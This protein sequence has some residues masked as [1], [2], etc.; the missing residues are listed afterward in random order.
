MAPLNYY[1]ILSAILFTIGITGVLVRKNPL[2]MFMSIELMLNAA[3]LAFVA[4]AY[5]FGT[6]EGQVL[7]FFVMTMAAAEVVVGLAIIS[8]I[9]RIR[10]NVD[11][12]EVS[13][14]KG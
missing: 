4:F 8:S 14:L 5:G 7:A 13:T 1:L 3:N 10:A 9:F 2:V 12:D 6:V 11:V